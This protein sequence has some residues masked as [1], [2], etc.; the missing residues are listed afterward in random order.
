MKKENGVFVF[1]AKR[2]KPIEVINK[3]KKRRCGGRRRRREMG[4]YI[5]PID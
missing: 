3:K 4:K 2:L 5:G 1:Y